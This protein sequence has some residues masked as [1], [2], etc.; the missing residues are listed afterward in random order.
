[1]NVSRTGSRFRDENQWGLDADMRGIF[2]G[3]LAPRELSFVG[4]A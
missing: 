1:M 4:T 3:V 2:T